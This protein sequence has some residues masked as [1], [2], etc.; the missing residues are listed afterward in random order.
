MSICG[1]STDNSSSAFAQGLSSRSTLLR[2]RGG[3]AGGALSSEPSRRCPRRSRDLWCPAAQ[4]LP[5]GR[6]LSAPSAVD[7]RYAVR[8]I[9]RQRRS[10]RNPARH[11]LQHALPRL[12]QSPPQQVPLLGDT[13]GL[14]GAVSAGPRPSPPPLRQPA[15]RRNVGLPNP[16]PQPVGRF[17]PPGF[18]DPAGLISRS[19]EASLT[20][21]PLP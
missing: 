20:R 19:T 3:C 11:R 15:Q 2:F 17:L 14:S 4:T 13:A 10:T 5:V 18:L 16:I 7:L 12:K 9:C 21:R 8:A 6:H 1:C